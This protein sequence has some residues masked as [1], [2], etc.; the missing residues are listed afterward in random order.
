MQA[1]TLVESGS[2][3]PPSP[4]ADATPYA[5]VADPTAATS[6]KPWSAAGAADADQEHPGVPA[7]PGVPAAR[8][9]LAAPTG[10]VPIGDEPAAAP[11]ARGRHPFTPPSRT[12]AYRGSPSADRL[13]YSAALKG[14]SNGVHHKDAVIR[15]GGI[16]L[17]GPD[18]PP[19]GDDAQWR[20]FWREQPEDDDAEP[21]TPIRAVARLGLILGV[22]LLAAGLVWAVMNAREH[23]ATLTKAAAQTSVLL[24]QP[25]R[26]VAEVTTKDAAGTSAGSALRAVP[27]K[28][29]LPK[30]APP[31][32]RLSPASLSL[33][34]DRAGSFALSCTGRCEIVSASGTNGIA[35]SGNDFQIRES[36][37]SSCDAEPAVRRGQITVRWAGRTTG[38]GR[39]TGGT[40]AGGGTLTMNVAWTVSRDDDRVC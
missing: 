21:G 5:P 30:P 26:W 28:T 35:V 31:V 33:G 10:D 20:E 23:P 9:P 12:R 15:Y 16:S 25:A 36:R 18:Q 37:S 14:E 19:G 34:Q 22:G 1:R 7:Q 39:R 17:S 11:A 3:S 38:D 24:E 27:R 32:A 2:S 6:G 4:V 8:Q 40:T 13:V 29:A